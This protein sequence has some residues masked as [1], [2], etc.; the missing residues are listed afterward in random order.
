[1]SRGAKTNRI[2]DYRK[3]NGAF[4]EVEEILEM[5]SSGPVLRAVLR[6]GGHGLVS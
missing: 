3:N 4:K 6:F 1:M 2:D 5:G